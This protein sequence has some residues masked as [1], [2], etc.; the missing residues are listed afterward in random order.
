VGTSLNLSSKNDNNRLLIETLDQWLEFLS[1]DREKVSFINTKVTPENNT[2]LAFNL[3]AKMLKR[4]IAMNKFDR[5]LALGLNAERTLNMTGLK[6]FGSLPH[7]I[8]DMSVLQN[9]KKVVK[10]LELCKRY[11][12]G[13]V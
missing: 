8:Q 3:S 10:S 12:H 4:F 1:I 7:P 6:G 9:K 11:L 2:D 13:N 5:I